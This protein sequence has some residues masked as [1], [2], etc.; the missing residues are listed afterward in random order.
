METPSESGLNS[1]IGDD[2]LWKPTGRIGSARRRGNYY[3]QGGGVNSS[4]SKKPL[5]SI[6]TDYNQTPSLDSQKRLDEFRRK[7]DGELE[8]MRKDKPAA[9]DREKRGV[10]PSGARPNATLFKYSELMTSVQN[11][12]D[13]KPTV[14]ITRNLEALVKGELSSDEDDDDD[15]RGRLYDPKQKNSTVVV[16]GKEFNRQ[17]GSFT[18]AI[19]SLIAIKDYNDKA[20]SRPASVPLRLEPP[21]EEKLYPELSIQEINSDSDDGIDDDDIRAITEHENDYLDAEE[22]EKEAEQQ[23]QEEEEGEEEEEEEV[24]EKYQPPPQPTTVISLPP[25]PV[26]NQTLQVPPQK[27]QQA[28]VVRRSLEDQLSEALARRGNMSLEQIQE[29]I[30]NNKKQTAEALK[31]DQQEKDAKSGNVLQFL[32]NAF[33]K[34][35]QKANDEGD[36]GEEEY[37]GMNQESRFSGRHGAGLIKR[38]E[39]SSMTEKIS[40]AKNGTVVFDFYFFL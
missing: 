38:K 33:D 31:K 40:R 14:K 22:E 35:F 30:D 4:V 20:S 6:N 15:H 7:Y 21:K 25:P 32:R 18:E 8:R 26:L 11:S 5:R 28:P 37:G 23:Q 2:D 9:S 39:A 19:D 10:V 27:R 34:K 17:I 36:D 16:N 1:T 12:N 29:K 24:E 13:E 3:S